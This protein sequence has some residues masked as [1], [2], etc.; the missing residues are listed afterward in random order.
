[1]QYSAFVLRHPLI[2][3]AVFGATKSWQLKEVLNASK[4]HLS[5]E[6]VAQINKVHSTCPNPSP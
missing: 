5:A 4:I 3:S 1:M 6:I 2:A